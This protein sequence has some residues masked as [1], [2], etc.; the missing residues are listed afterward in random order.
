MRHVDI[1][2]ADA[3]I[4]G[5]TIQTAEGSAFTLPCMGDFAEYTLAQAEKFSGGCGFR[6]RPDCSKTPAVTIYPHG[7]GG[8]G[9]VATQKTTLEKTSCASRT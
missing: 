4:N 8:T 6:A 1:S 2:L 3:R 7:F 5:T 9:N